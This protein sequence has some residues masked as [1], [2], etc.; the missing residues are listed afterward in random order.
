MY[1]PKW[2]RTPL[3]RARF[4][5]RI[6][7]III[8]CIRFVIIR[9][10]NQGAPGILDQ[11]NDMGLLFIRHKNLRF[12]FLAFILLIFPLD[13]YLYQ[14]PAQGTNTLKRYISQMILKKSTDIE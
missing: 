11:K 14:T 7:Y 5:D 9:I 3:R 12:L 2:R 13:K 8:A 6:A 10:G 4:S 1:Q